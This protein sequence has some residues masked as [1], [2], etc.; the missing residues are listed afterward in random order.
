MVIVARA[1]KIRR[2]DG[3]EICAELTPIGLAQLNAGYL[4]YRV[5]FV[6]GLE[7]AGQQLVLRHGLGCEPRINTR[8]PEEHQLVHADRVGAADNVERDREVVGN[9][10]SRIGAVGMNSA[11][12]R[13][14]EENQV[15]PIAPEPLFGRTLVGKIKNSVVG[16]KNLA[17]LAREPACYRRTPHPPVAGDID[18][19]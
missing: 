6:G 18:T 7:R 12:P 15:G 8:G 17:A 2:H 9:K 11:D 4:G 13:S 10:I 19:L 3:N 16:T 14:S 1:V 5:P